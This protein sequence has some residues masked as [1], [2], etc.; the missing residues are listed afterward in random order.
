MQK[1][2]NN[3]DNIYCC[4]DCGYVFV[5]NASIAFI[6][7]IIE[8]VNKKIN[9]YCNSENAIKY[10]SNSTNDEYEH[11]N[12]VFNDFRI[13]VKIINIFR[14]NKQ[15]SRSENKHLGA[16]FYNIIELAK[17]VDKITKE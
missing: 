2:Y 12:K 3:R 11:I 9:D 8:K 10:D 4:D 6:E 13:E 7:D 16:A 17:A 14:D 1:T 15:I 5:N